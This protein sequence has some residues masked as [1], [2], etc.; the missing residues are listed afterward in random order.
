M[1]RLFKIFFLVI[2]STVS[3]AGDYEW[4]D[5][6][7]GGLT[8]EGTYIWTWDF[9]QEP[10]PVE[11]TGYI[12]G[13]AA[14]E[15]VW[16]KNAGT[17]NMSYGVYIGDIGFDIEDIVPDSVY[18]KL[19]APEGIQDGDR[20]N[21]WLYDPRNSTWDNAL[22]FELE[23]SL[24]VL[25]D[26]QWHQFS[27][28]LSDF[29]EYKDPIDYTNI[30]AVSIERPTEDD[31]SEFPMMYIDHVWVGDPMVPV[32]ITI[33]DGKKV[34][35]GIEFAAWGFENNELQIADGEGATD[36]TSALVWETSNGEGW[37]GQ[38]FK[39]PPQNF[40]HCWETDTLNLLVKAP[41]GINALSLGFYDKDGN[42]VWFPADAE[43]F[44]F[45]GEWKHLSIP[46]NKFELYWDS[47]DYANVTEFRLENG[48]ENQQI[49]ER[50]L[51]DQ[52]YTSNT[53]GGL[54][55]V[56]NKAP[57]IAASF[58]LEQNYPNPF[59]PTTTIA[60][61]LGKT[62]MATLAVYNVIGEKVTELVSENLPA[63]R[64]TFQWDAG[65]MPS[66]TYFYKLV[67]EAFSQ[68]RKMLLIR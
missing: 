39:F 45:D 61:E 34:S 44:G 63:G 30:I 26:K 14:I 52:I 17:E 7:T 9:V 28:G 19:R 5:F 48:Y 13:T 38:Q 59:N 33:F 23:E 54:T 49:P 25:Q 12:P 57:Q 65:D 18:F 32:R 64:H 4:I 37:Q 40:T 35:G 21:V 51:F 43:T 24:A 27:V 15:V 11:D 8:N 66:G 29:W 67:T 55:R 50:L 3:L 58:E 31:D 22:L 68:T 41:A 6:Y 42:A 10:G 16:E 46:L 47:F 56:Q 20:L 53:G 2:M 36:S 1:M 62:S 60:F